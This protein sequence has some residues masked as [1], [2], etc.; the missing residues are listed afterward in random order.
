MATGC[1]PSV[2]RGSLVFCHTMNQIGFCPSARVDANGHYRIKLRPGRYALLPA[3]AS[4][5]VVY[6]RPRWVTL[7]AGEYASLVIDGGN[8]MM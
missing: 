6:V 5:N 3:P 2:Y 7:A 4:G 8:L 1:A